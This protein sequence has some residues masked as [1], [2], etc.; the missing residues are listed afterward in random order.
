[1]RDEDGSVPSPD[2]A[3][4]S[5]HPGELFDVK[6]NLN[7]T[8][9]TRPRFHQAAT[10]LSP[11][12][13]YELSQCHRRKSLMRK[14]STYA[15]EQKRGVE[16]PQIGKEALDSSDHVRTVKCIS[17]LIDLVGSV[18]IVHFALERWLF[19]QW[20]VLKGRQQRA[21]AQQS[22]RR[23]INDVTTSNRVKCENMN[24][25]TVKSHH[26]AK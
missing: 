17:K 1:M 20:F 26:L 8:P 3:F 13:P 10:G 16:V 7:N 14:S 4:S 15:R 23:K 21:A 5:P 18:F 9:L 2:F 19:F 6:K 12:Q 22:R 25:V 11:Y 24:T